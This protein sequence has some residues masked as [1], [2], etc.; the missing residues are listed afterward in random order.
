MLGPYDG[1]IMA[2]EQKRRRR[3]I[4]LPCYD[5]CREGVYFVTICSHQRE[6]I[7]GETKEGTLKLNDIGHVVKDCWE[8]IPKHFPNMELDQYVI[9]PNHIHGLIVIERQLPGR[10]RSSPD[11]NNVAPQSLGV[12]VRSF[13]A[14]VSRAVKQ[15]SKGSVSPVWQR[16]YFEHVVRNDEDFSRI[17]EYIFLNPIQWEEDEDNPRWDHNPGRHP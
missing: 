7:L 15:R 5:Y 10:K 3:S 9:M 6:C 13:K 12:V 2:D 8:E 1:W 17:R 11:R 14:A 16:N 4:R